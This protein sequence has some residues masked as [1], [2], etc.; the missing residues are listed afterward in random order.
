LLDRARFAHL[1]TRRLRKGGWRYLTER[2]V[3]RLKQ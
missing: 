2:E 3:A 1:N